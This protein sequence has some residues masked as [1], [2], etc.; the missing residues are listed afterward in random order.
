[1]RRATALAGIAAAL[2]AGCGNG[3]DGA[4]KAVN[5]TTAKLGQI[6]SGDIS[7]EVLVEPQGVQGGGP[8]GFRMSG[9]FQLR[10]RGQLPDLKMDYTQIAAG[11]E[12]TATLTAVGGKAWVG[13]SGK[14]QPLPAASAKQL[15]TAAG[16]SGSKQGL[17]AL[18]VNL[19]DW[20]R[21]AK[22]SED[23]ATD[24]ITGNVDVVRALDDLLKAARR[25]GAQIS[26]SSAERIRKSVRT[27]DVELVTGHDDRLLRLLRLALDFEV[28]KEMRALTGGMNRAAIKLSFKVDRPNQPVRITPPSGS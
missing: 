28:P 1:M 10:G 11:K 4:R 7:M 18:G 9:P 26:D 21:D 19:G 27:S 17:A 2:V 24:R 14:T 22:L 5:D 23:G 16:G 13:A 8:T 12:G 15:A 20:V 25:G 3:G 6:R